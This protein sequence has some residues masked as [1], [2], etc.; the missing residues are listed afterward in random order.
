MRSWFKAVGR[1]L[2]TLCAA[3]AFSVPFVAAADDWSWLSRPQ[4][5]QTDSTA[6]RK[7]DSQVTEIRPQADQNE[8]IYQVANKPKSKK[9][10][11]AWNRMW[12]PSQWFSS[13][14]SSKR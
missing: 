5:Q 1:T 14:K 13:S 3:A 10:T 4:S 9:Q 11:S 7:D 12:H 6:V 8:P 2:G